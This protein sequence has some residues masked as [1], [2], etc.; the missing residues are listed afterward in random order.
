[1]GDDPSFLESVGLVF[2]AIAFLMWVV[3][4]VLEEQLIGKPRR[5]RQRTVKAR[6]RAEKKRSAAVRLPRAQVHR[7]P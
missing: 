7:S 5:E 1:V 2:G 6:A 3:S 4:D